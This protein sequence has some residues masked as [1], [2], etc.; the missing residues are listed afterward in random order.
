ML[1]NNG[2]SSAIVPE[3]KVSTSKMVTIL[4]AHEHAEQYPMAKVEIYK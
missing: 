1:N 4:C 2:A 3:T